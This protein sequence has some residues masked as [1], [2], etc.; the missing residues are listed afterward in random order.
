M[1]K[2]HHSPPEMGGEGDHSWSTPDAAGTVWITWHM[3]TRTNS[4]YGN[5]FIGANID[6]NQR[7]DN[8]PRDLQLVRGQPRTQGGAVLFGTRYSCAVLEDALGVRRTD[9]FPLVG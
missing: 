1:A 2:G 7:L 4:F 5:A 6:P 8:M 9:C 3:L